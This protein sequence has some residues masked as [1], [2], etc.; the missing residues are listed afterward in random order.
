MVE[1]GKG[2]SGSGRSGEGVPGESTHYHIGMAG[3]GA[4][5]TALRDGSY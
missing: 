5:I 1:V 4:M 3:E 2:A